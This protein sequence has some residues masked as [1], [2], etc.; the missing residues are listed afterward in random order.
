MS[1]KKV[2]WIYCPPLDE[3][4]FGVIAKVNNEGKRIDAIEFLDEEELIAELICDANAGSEGK[5]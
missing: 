3:D 2:K 5:Q 4:S 1:E